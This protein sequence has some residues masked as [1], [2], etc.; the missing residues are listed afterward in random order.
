LDQWKST[1]A[2]A[3]MVIQAA[4]SPCARGG[5]AKSLIFLA[6]ALWP[7]LALRATGARLLYNRLLAAAAA[8]G[9]LAGKALALVL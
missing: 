8:A 9:A 7:A 3:G 5:R 1:A 6:G 2:Q 4:A